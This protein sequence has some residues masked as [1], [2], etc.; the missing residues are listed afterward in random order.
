[1]KVLRLF[2]KTTFNWDLREI[3]TFREVLLDLLGT[4]RLQIILGH[5]PSAILLTDQLQSSY[6]AILIEGS[7]FTV[8]VVGCAERQSFHSILGHAP[9]HFLFEMSFI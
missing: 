8:L 2:G 9:I 3:L 1:M 4:I 6:D 5:A 7:I